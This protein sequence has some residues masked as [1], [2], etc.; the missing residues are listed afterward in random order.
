MVRELPNG[1]LQ[2]VDGHLRAETTPNALVPVL[3][4]DLDDKDADKVLATFDPLA[5]HAAQ[6]LK[7]D[8]R[9]NLRSSAGF[10][11]LPFAIHSATRRL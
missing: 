4:V 6:S 1:S 2:I 10:A 11:E 9:P 5:A 8:H 7:F 3:V